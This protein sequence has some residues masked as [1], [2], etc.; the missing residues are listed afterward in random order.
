MS[1]PPVPLSRAVRLGLAGALASRS[2]LAA[3][4]AWLLVLAAAYASDAGPPRGA[5]AFTAALL[6]PVAA[7]ATAAFLAAS[8]DD[9]RALLAAADGRGRVLLADALPPALWVGAAAL[10]GTLAG[11][12]FD[13]RPAPAVDRLLVLA[14]HLGCGAVGVALALLLHAGR[15]SR[16]TQVVAVVAATLA[17]G[18]LAWL[19]PVG[20]VLAAWTSGRTP[21]TSLAV[22]S[23][24]GPL[25]VAAL[26]A[27]GTAV[28][29]RR[30]V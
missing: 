4:F 24:T 8:S 11:L 5:G 15:L 2:L 10:L 23:L 20:P 7:W 18:R 6:L 16:G 27:A 26:L 9:V 14:L 13:A 3:S 12:L 17:S 19:P 22:W 25:V 21:A 30:A 29:R 28:L 1:G